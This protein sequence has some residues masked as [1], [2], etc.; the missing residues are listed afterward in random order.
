[1]AREWCACVWSTPSFSTPRNH[2]LAEDGWAIASHIALAMLM[3]L[4]PFLIFVTALAGF[5]GSQDLADESRS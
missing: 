1:M 3:S 2:F 4:F 5:F